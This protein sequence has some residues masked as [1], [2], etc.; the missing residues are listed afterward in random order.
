MILMKKEKRLLLI[1]IMPYKTNGLFF[2][3][4]LVYTFCT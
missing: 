2:V 4:E 3:A 1:L